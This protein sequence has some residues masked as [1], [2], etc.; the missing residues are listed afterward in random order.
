MLEIRDMGATCIEL[1]WT[2]I[3]TGVRISLSLALIASHVIQNQQN[4]MDPLA[5]D[6]NI[7]QNLYKIM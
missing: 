5:V 6:A 7:A 1:F 2:C 4:L 3:R